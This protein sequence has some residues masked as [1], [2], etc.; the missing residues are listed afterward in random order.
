[1]HAV[2]IRQDHEQIGV[3][4]VRDE[5]RQPVV[6]AEADLLDGDRVVL[7]DD[8]NHAEREQA[9]QRRARVEVPLATD[10]IVLREKDLPDLHLPARERALI[11]VHEHPLPDRGRRLK[12]RDV[13]G[14]TLQAQR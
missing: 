6:I 2:H 12:R 4:E 5:R 7:V 3:D 9:V 8:R 10:E 14:T 11:R 1:M 13:L